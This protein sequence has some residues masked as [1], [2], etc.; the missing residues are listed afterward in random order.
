[1]LPNIVDISLVVV[2]R[3]GHPL[4]RKKK[5]NP[6][7][8][9]EYP[10]ITMK[11][12]Y[13]GRNRLGSFFVSQNLEPPRARIVV[14][15]GIHSLDLLHHADYLT[16]IP[17]AMLPLARKVGVEKVNIAASFWDSSAGLVYRTSN[18]PLPIITSLV[19]TLRTLTAEA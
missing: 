13:I 2:A 9:L 11:A 4:L 8:L 14:G 10:W 19:A 5:V 12:D 16:T 15:P 3:K 1:M 6:E 17:T 7:D 18:V